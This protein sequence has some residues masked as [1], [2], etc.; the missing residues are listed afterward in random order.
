MKITGNDKEFV[1][2]PPY[3]GQA[4]C[5]DITEPKEM[6]GFSGGKVL[7]FRIVFETKCLGDDGKPQ[8]VW[9]APF[10]MTLGDKSNL[11]K[12]VRQM[13]GRDL[14]PEELK[15]GF[16]M[17]SLLGRNVNIVIVHNTEG[18]KTYANIAAATPWSGPEMKAS[19][20][21]KRKVKSDGK[22]NPPPQG[23]APT[24]AGSWLTCKV[25]TGKFNGS[26]LREI[27]PDA[28]QRIIDNWLPGKLQDGEAKQTADDKR[29]IA[30]LREYQAWRAAEEAKKAQP[31]AAEP[32]DV[33]Y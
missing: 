33:P 1:P 4:V 2:H 10:T 29:L 16:D 30:A 12:F 25:H 15:E 19:G 6:D 14:T 27:P 7:K 28:I 3:N 20:N 9:S 8:C 22:P 13:L 32:D 21:Y 23:Q 5:V 31:A 18:D 24:A 17:D 11:R 26:E